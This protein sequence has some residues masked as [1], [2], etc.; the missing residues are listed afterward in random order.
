MV[1]SRGAR[2]ARR[3]RTEG[4]DGSEAHLA[5]SIA[6]FAALFLGLTVVFFL[7]FDRFQGLVGQAYVRPISRAASLLLHGIGI[8]SEVVEE[9]HMGMCT[10]LLGEVSYRITQGCTGL[11]TSALFVAGV[12]SYPVEAGSKVTG[13]LIGIPAFFVFGVLRVVIMAIVAVLVP[14]R[15]EI[16]HVYI[17][18]IANLGFAMFVWIYWFNRVS[19]GEQLGSVSG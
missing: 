2:S 19:A 4:D 5:G 11:F 1:P 7:L 12:L 8:R 16:F 10:L 15:V 9:L 14:S 3:R 6:R 13:L 18:A 17:M